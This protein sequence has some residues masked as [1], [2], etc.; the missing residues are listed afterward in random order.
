MKTIKVTIALATA[1][2][3]FGVPG[4]QAQENVSKHELSLAVQ[5]LG[6]G[7]MPFRGAM[8]WEDQPGLS[9]GFNVGYTYWFG[10]HFGF[11][12]GVRMSSISHNQKISNFNHPLTANLELTTINP[13]FS[14]G[15]TEVKL[16]GTAT[17]IQEEQQY[18]YLELPLQLA[19]RCKGWFANVGVSL[20]KAVSAT[21]D[22]SFTK[23]EL[24][25]TE[26]PALGVS[27]NPPV[28]MTLNSETKGSVK[29]VDMAKPF[30][31]LLD[32]EVGYNIPL[33]DATNL[34]VGL[35]G[36]FAPIAH[37]TNNTVDIYALQ[38][39][40]TFTVCQPATSAQ[41]EK[42]GYYEVGVM[43]GVNFGLKKKQKRGD[44][45]SVLTPEESRYEQMAAEVAALKAERQ[46]ADAELAAMKAAQK[47]SENELAAMKAAQQ[48]AE[49]EMAAM[50]AAREKEGKA[51]AKATN[52]QEAK[53]GQQQAVKQ[54]QGSLGVTVHFD[55]KGTRVNPTAEEEA[56]IQAICEAMKADAGK[57]AVVTGY[58]D[59]T[60]SAK[61]NRRYSRQRAEALKAYMV[62]LGAPAKNI[63]CVGKGE[64][65][66][67]ADNGT[68]EGR[69]LNRRAT[70]EVE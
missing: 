58:T 20:T 33:A 1:L 63:K 36:R 9:I 15:S 70:V 53:A 47:K 60:G 50:K 5:G 17:S 24:G 38:P 27:P 57:T 3:L 35:Y 18:T 28:P 13:A 12:T 4:T 68:T 34:A 51:D 45:G 64:S 32:A 40:A 46:K 42:R 55:F 16:Q 56:A 6:L 69:A 43:L 23:P 54:Q 52:Q 31:L 37:T 49:S 10:E 62:R 59:N 22:Y 41:V 39:D 25:I 7:S 67:V 66:P 30:Y 44:D 2:F 26:I 61:A 11:R 29:N 48:K 21:A 8:T 14:S 65:D 19:M